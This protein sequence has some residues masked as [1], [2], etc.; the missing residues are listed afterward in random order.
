MEPD[1]NALYAPGDKNSRDSFKIGPSS[2]LFREQLTLPPGRTKH[3]IFDFEGPGSDQDDVEE[4]IGDNIPL[5][6]S[7]ESLKGRRFDFPSLVSPWW[8]TP[9]PRK[10]IRND[11]NRRIPASHSVIEILP[12][13]KK[14]SASCMKMCLRQRLVHP[15]QC[16]SL[17]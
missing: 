2:L 11:S 12:P 6:F 15:S 16:H 8:G 1:S 17:C 5:S 10:A 14:R 3:E 9:A 7:L 13:A 4:M